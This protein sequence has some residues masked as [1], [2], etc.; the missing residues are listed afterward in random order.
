LVE[1]PVDVKPAPKRRKTTSKKNDS[2]AGLGAVDVK[3]VVPAPYNYTGPNVYTPTLLPPTL[4][5]SLPDAISHLTTHDPRFQ[6][7]FDHIPCQPFQPPLEAIDPFKTL[8]TSIIGQQVSW[9]AARAI[10]K[11]FRELFGF[12]DEE[13]YPSPMQVA[14]EDVMRLKSVGLSM[15]K[16]EYGAFLGFGGFVG[17]L[18]IGDSW[19]TAVICLAQHFV[20]GRLSTELLRDGTDEEVAKALIAVRGI[21]QVSW[22][23]PVDPSRD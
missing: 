20:D 15:R 9:M 22:P 23:S 18:A 21:G 1:L 13:G 10:N 4:S 17:A 7:F 3:P 11:R 16:A 12:E 2:A 19:L 8:V 5:F 6:S 14:G